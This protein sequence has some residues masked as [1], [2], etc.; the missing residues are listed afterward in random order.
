VTTILAFF[1]LWAN[2]NIRGTT[3]SFG[4]PAEKDEKKPEVDSLDSFALE[5][6]EVSLL[7]MNTCPHGFCAQ[8][9]L[10]YMVSSGTDQQPAKP[11]KGVLFLLQRSG[12]MAISQ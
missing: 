11:S 12:L 6:W 3:G 10:H 5:R 7:L 1:L 9:I 8:T 2:F 4:V